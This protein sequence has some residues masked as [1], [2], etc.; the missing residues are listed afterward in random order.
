VNENVDE[1]IVKSLSES[2]YQSG[3]DIKKLMMDI[4]SSSWF[5]DKKISATG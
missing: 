5:Y 4:F 1:N 2:F 3:Y